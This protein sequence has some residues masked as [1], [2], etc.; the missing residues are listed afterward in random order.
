MSDAIRVAL[1][2]AIRTYEAMSPGVMTVDRQQA[3]NALQALQHSGEVAVDVTGMDEEDA[4]FTQIEAK[5]RATYRRHTFSAKGQIITRADGYESHLVWAAVDWALQRE[6]TQIVKP[7]EA[8]W[9]LREVYFDDVDGELEITA[10]RA[11]QP[12]VPEGWKIHKKDSAFTLTHPDG[13]ELK[14]GYSNGGIMT[15]MLI[16]LC[17]ALLSASKG[18]E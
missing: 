4:M 3:I 1:E 8:G 18:G 16:E 6:R 15:H 7:G 11:P 2:S 9:Q 5:A 10:Y 12:A 17:E 13:T 14:F